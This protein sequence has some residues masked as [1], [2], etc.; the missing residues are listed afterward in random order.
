MAILSTLIGSLKDSLLDWQF[1]GVTIG[2]CIAGQIIYDEFLSPGSKIPG[3]RLRFLR[4]FTAMY[5]IVN[6]DAMNYH[7]ELNKKYGSVSWLLPNSVSLADPDAVRMICTSTKLVKANAY[8]SFQ[9]H[10]DNIFSTQDVAFH[11]KLVSSCAMANKV[12]ANK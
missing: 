11:R 8:Q 3:P 12:L 2:A 10:R 1:I 5:H 6:G 9:F 4:R 7:N